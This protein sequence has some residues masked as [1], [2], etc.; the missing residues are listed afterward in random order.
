[1]GNLLCSTLFAGCSIEIVILHQMNTESFPWFWN[2]KLFMHLNFGYCTNCIQYCDYCS[3]EVS[4]WSSGSQ[5]FQKWQ[6][7][8]TRLLQYPLVL[9]PMKEDTV[10]SIGSNTINNPFMTTVCNMD[11]GFITYRRV[12]YLLIKI[13][14]FLGYSVNCNDKY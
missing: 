14:N 2:T 3:Y 11:I 7:C 1:M 4:D 12:V 8:L 9:V 5:N 10:I 13:Y 6:R